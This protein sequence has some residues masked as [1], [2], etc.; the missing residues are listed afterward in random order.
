MRADVLFYLLIV[1]IVAATA[2]LIISVVLPPIVSDETLDTVAGL[3]VVAVLLFGTV[4]AWL[5]IRYRWPSNPRGRV[6][7]RD[8]GLAWSHMSD[9]RRARF[10]FGEH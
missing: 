3:S 9:P 5:Y 4:T 1:A 10:G 6:F 8:I 2:L 7:D